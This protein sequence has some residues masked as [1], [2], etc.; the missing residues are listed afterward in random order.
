[1]A[2]RWLYETRATESSTAGTGP[3][4]LLQHVPPPT[5]WGCVAAVPALLTPPCSW[6]IH[7]EE[8]ELPHDDAQA[9]LL[10]G[11]LTLVA[12]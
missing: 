3:C 1:M 7:G 5:P 8:E 11:D 6:L 4:L 9:L 2:D 12:L 10:E